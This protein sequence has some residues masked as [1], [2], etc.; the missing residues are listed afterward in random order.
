MVAVAMLLYSTYHIIQQADILTYLYTYLGFLTRSPQM[1]SFAW[2]ETVE[3]SSSGK[4]T[5]AL[6]MLTKVSLSVSPPKGV[7]PVRNTYVS[8]PTDL[9]NVQEIL[10]CILHYEIPTFTSAF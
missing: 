4:S 2:S 6:V 7:H 9:P 1:K 5:S 8:T 3:K 10:I